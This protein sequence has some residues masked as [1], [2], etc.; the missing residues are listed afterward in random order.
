MIKWALPID[1]KRT[2]NVLF[3]TLIKKITLEK[4]SKAQSVANIKWRTIVGG[5]ENLMQDC[6][7]PFD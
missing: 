7:Y 5:K 3:E 2:L 4:V 6:A 1:S